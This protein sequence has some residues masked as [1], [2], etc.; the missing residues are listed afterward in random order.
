MDRALSGWKPH[1]STHYD[2]VKE[3]VDPRNAVFS[4]TVDTKHITRQKEEYVL[5][6]IN[7]VGYLGGTFNVMG[8]AYVILFGASKIRPWGLAQMYLLRWSSSFYAKKYIIGAG[9]PLV[10]RILIDSEMQGE[11]LAGGKQKLERSGNTKSIS[12]TDEHLSEL[13]SLVSSVKICWKVFY[14]N[15]TLTVPWFKTST[16]EANA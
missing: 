15:T 6:W 5:K 13:R 1:T 12:K 11:A 2:I 10:E 3:G 8:T 9:L 14:L 16:E 4:L 7:F